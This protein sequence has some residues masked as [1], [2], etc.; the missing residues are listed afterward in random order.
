MPE[1]VELIG[2]TAARPLISV[3]GDEKGA[4]T[5]DLFSLTVEETPQGLFRCEATF[6]DF[7]PT[8]DGSVGSQYL[9]R[10]TIDF[11][12][13][14]AVDT[15]AGDEWVTVFDGQVTGIEA[16]LTGDEPPS[17]TVLAEDRLQALR[18]QRRTRT[19]EDVTDREVAQQ[20]ARDHSLQTEINVDGP[21]HSVLAQVNQ[22]DL[23]FLR[24]RARAIDAEVWI[25]GDTLHFE[26]HS[27]REE[28]ALSVEFGVGLREFSVLADLARQ[29]TAF[30]VGGWEVDGKTAIQETATEAAI[31]GELD[32]G[33]S[34]AELLE[35]AFE[36]R[37]ETMVHSVPLTTDEAKGIAEAEFRRRA[38]RFVEGEGVAV[39]D[40]RIR[41]GLT[42]E[43]TGVGG[44]FDG[45]YTVTRATHTFDHRLGYQT[46]FTVQRPYL[47][48]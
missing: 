3:D 44:G 47:R 12:Q 35:E 46:E 24:D 13:A 45:A 27:R 25:E 34:G 42:L 28:G 6:V 16:H 15:T 26:S 4:L 39:G 33:R 30:T 43:I 20:I 5:E 11:G 21:T 2:S 31:Q 37:T 36:E 38:R 17:L 10:Q 29:Q 9:D 40:G 23:A 1:R 19:F 48:P 22:S 14:F 7:G 18:M 32:G 41:V 8:G